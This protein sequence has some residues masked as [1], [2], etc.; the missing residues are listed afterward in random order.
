[1]SVVGA[2]VVGVLLGAIGLLSVGYYLTQKHR[3]KAK[4]NLNDA[5]EALKKK[6]Q[7]QLAQDK[8]Y[9]EKVRG[10][11]DRATD[12]SMQQAEIMAQ[13]QMP[14]KNS[15]HSKYK[16]QL[17]AEIKSLEEEK[18]AILKSIITDGYNP[19]VNVTLESGEHK[20][21]PLKE[22]MEYLGIPTGPTEQ[23][24]REQRKAKFTVI[25]GGKSET[26]N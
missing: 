21:M 19:N 8:I 17:V 15:L 3:N 24:L 1:M 25:Q 22:Y 6:A 5:L 7:E 16:N 11:L 10:R 26:T 18:C 4:K 12:I 20:T 9:D 13:L 23:E 2:M 14:S